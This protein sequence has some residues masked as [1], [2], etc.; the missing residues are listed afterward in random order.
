MSSSSPKSS[1]SFILPPDEKLEADVAAVGR[2]GAIKTVLRLLLRITGLRLAVV[3]R[4]TDESWTCCAVLDEINFGLRP[5][6][7]LELVTTFCNTVRGLGGPLLIRHASEDPRCATH[8]APKLYG[9]E[10]YIA[11]PLYRRDGS[12]FGVL[13]A[14]DPR[15]ALLSEELLETFRD[16]ADLVGHQLEQE[17]ALGQRDAQLL[18]AH[19]ATKLRE[20]L[21][22]IV[23]HDL[24]SPLNAIAL[25]AELLLRR[26]GLDDRLRGGLHRIL[27][28]ADR[29][30]RLIR[31]L[32]DFTQA[33][34]GQQLPVKRQQMDLHAIAGQVVDELRQAAPGRRLELDC[35]GD[36]QGAWDPDRVTQVLTN[37]LTN[38]LQY[39]PAE[40]PIRVTVRGEAESVILAVSNEGPPIPAHLLPT[41]FEPMT[42]G[43]QEGGERRS[44]GLGLFIVDQIVRAHGGHVDVRSRE[45]EGTVFRVH[46]PR[47]VPVPGEAS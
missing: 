9:V 3:A 33:R 19:E 20:Q 21:I 12:F 5:G 41:L 22:G 6:D 11:V 26:E 42:R 44:I 14:L 31:D 36:G 28:S 15:P 34:M 38:A 43:T 1:P 17:E 7:K 45:V 39:S 30:N 47:R 27:E 8:P 13:C 32:L 18:G 46:L 23:S 16:L 10:S 2:I 37:L 25:S 4:V 24:R 29:A 35:Q 40:S